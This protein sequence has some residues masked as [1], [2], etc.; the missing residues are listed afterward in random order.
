MSVVPVEAELQTLD[1]F[2]RGCA[3]R[4]P[5]LQRVMLA[6]RK[7]DRLMYVVGVEVPFFGSAQLTILVDQN[8]ITRRP[9]VFVADP[10][11][12]RHRF[13]SGALCMWYE[14]DPPERRWVFDDGLMAL[15]DLASLHLYRE[16]RYRETGRWMGEEA[17]HGLPWH[18][19][20]K[21]GEGKR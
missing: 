3:A 14:F 20:Y 4:F 18:P 19:G 8:D 1:A 9:Q 12:M 11:P 2:E 10:R 13:D 15:V 6:G 16:E 7:M 5:E 21:R 17:P